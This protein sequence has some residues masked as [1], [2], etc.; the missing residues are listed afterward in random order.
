MLLLIIFFIIIALIEIPKLI[1]KKYVK[2]IT[3]SSILIFTAFIFSTLY[4][5]DIPI[6]NPLDLIIYLIR[7]LLH[8]S[9]G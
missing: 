9:Y 2:E 4:I 8:L 3:V 1:K 7:D 6:F 5:L